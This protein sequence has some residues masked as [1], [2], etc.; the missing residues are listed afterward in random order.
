MSFKCAI[1]NRTSELGE[2]CNKIVVETRVATY[3]HWDYEEE[4][5]WFSYGTETVREVSASERGLR[6]WN[7]WSDEQKAVFVSKLS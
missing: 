5:E 1:T 2:K 6:L 3:R 7:S 4:A